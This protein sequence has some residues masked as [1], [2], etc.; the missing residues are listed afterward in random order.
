MVAAISNR[1]GWLI[2]PVID[3][4]FVCGG[5]VWLMLLVHA[6][7]APG[8]FGA[9]PRAVDL[10]PILGLFGTMLLSDTHNAATL[11]KLYTSERTR[12]K[13]KFIA[14][15]GAILFLALGALLLLEPSLLSPLSKIYLILI[16]QHVTA[17][18]YGLAVMYCHK[19]NYIMQGLQARLFKLSFQSLTLYAILCQFAYPGN[20]RKEFFGVPIPSWG[21]LPMPLLYASLTIAA[22]IT[23]SF[24]ALTIRRA[25]TE[26]QVLPLPAIMLSVSVV[27]VA[28]T[29]ANCSGVLSLYI[30][31]FFHGAQYLVVGF[32]SECNEAQNETSQKN[33]M[34]YA[35]KLF[36]LTLVLFALTPFALTVTGLPF[37]TTFLAV[38]LAINL[39]HFVADSFM[40]RL[41]DTDVRRAI[42]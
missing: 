8:S 6:C 25:V 24:V 21:G 31:A 4:L 18:A 9:G 5:F 7:I 40:W 23:A 32:A 20:F 13:H 11:L 16:V 33:A 10:F 19:R 28:A 14:G 17:Q 15:I 12:A 37:G 36:L 42:V 30:P 29:V 1:R 27:F 38:F 39:H 34:R 41:S 3:S 35:A 2:N 26:N 22:A